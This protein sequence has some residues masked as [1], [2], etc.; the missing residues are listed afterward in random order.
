MNIKI[1]QEKLEKINNIIY[2]LIDS[3]IDLN[4]VNMTN[5]Y[6]VNWD[7]DEE[8]DDPYMEFYYLGDWLGE[9]DSDIIFTYFHPEYYDSDSPS[10]IQHRNTAP[11]LEVN[12]EMLFNMLDPFGYKLYSPVL[13][14]W[15][16]NKF[17]LPVKSVTVHF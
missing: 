12:D 3:Y 6:V 17:N 5:P 15:F 8:Y 16:M 14:K 13:S 1:N 10:E 11:I 9:D 4:D 2:R 7:T